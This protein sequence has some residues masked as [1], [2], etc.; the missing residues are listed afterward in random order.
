MCLCIH[1]HIYIYMY[2]YT[3]TYISYIYIY[4]RVCICVCIDIRKYVYIY[5][6]ICIHIYSTRI[7]LK[8]IDIQSLLEM[9]LMSRP[10][11]A[12]LIEKLSTRAE[13]VHYIAKWRI[14]VFFTNRFGL[15]YLAIYPP[16]IITANVRPP[17]A[18]RR[19]ISL[20]LVK[21]G[22]VHCAPRTHSRVDLIRVKGALCA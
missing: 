5:T 4:I 11:F 1:T 8:I 20:I 21:L 14:T 22:P 18:S 9:G 17:S 16:S 3:H 13:G 19:W 6:Y 2:I 15:I 12:F 7:C 10:Q